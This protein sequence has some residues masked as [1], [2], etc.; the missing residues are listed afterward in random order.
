MSTSGGVAGA[1]LPASYNDLLGWTFDLEC[2]VQAEAPTA[3]ASLQLLRIPIS[4]TTTVTNTLLTIAAV[5]NTVTHCYTALYT[6][7][8][9]VVGQSADQSSAWGTGGS[10]FTA[11]TVALSGGPYTV[12][13]LS[14]DDFVWGAIYI[15]TAVSLPTFYA[16]QTL[17]AFV[18]LG[19]TASRRRL[20]TYA[21]SNTATLPNITPG[22]IVSGGNGMWMGIN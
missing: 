1:T 3:A 11:L 6:S 21:V 8:G 17:A 7:A 14:S 18:N 5:G 10:A 16:A 19:T 9:T 15:G 22:S 20:G 13:P 4:V 2:C 12:T